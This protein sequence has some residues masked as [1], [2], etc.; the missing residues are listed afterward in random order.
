M[1][2]K[3][4][5][6]NLLCVLMKEMED[7]HFNGM[8]VVIGNRTFTAEDCFDIVFAIKTLKMDRPGRFGAATSSIDSLY[9]SGDLAE[10]EYQVIAILL[11]NAIDRNGI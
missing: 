6:T 2:Y 3:A 7:V 8:N 10:S 11:E 4:K 1:N 5:Y 9:V